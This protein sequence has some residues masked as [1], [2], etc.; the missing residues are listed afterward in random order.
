M[1]LKEQVREFSRLSITELKSKEKEF[2]EE[3]FWLKIKHRSGQLPNFASLTRTKKN[4]A[5]IKTFIKAK[6]L[7]EATRGQK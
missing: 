5:R 7:N 4:L 3:I 1:K 2:S 6:E